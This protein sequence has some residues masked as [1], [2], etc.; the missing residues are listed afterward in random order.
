MQ[1]LDPTF[2]LAWRISKAVQGAAVAGSLTAIL[3]LVA[4]CGGIIA[5]GR[6]RIACAAE[7]RA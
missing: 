5:R 2:G 4:F 6:N 7:A 1:R 3:L